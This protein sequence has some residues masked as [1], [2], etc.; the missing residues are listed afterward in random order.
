MAIQLIPPEV[1]DILAGQRP[2][3]FFAGAGISK[4]LP[5]GLPLGTDLA[6]GIISSACRDDRFLSA[7]LEILLKGVDDS[8]QGCRPEVLLEIARQGIGNR[9]V[10]IL[11]VLDAQDPNVYHYV[12]AHALIEGNVVITTNFDCMIEKAY[13]RVAERQHPLT[14]IITE[15]DCRNASATRLR[16][17]FL[18]KIHGSLF[19]RNGRRAYHS[20]QATLASMAIGLAPWKRDLLK[21]LVGGNDV[22]FLGYSGNDDF[23]VGPFLASYPCTGRFLWAKYK[24]QPLAFS[25]IELSNSEDKLDHVDLLVLRK[26]NS[27]VAEGDTRQLLSLLPFFERALAYVSNSSRPLSRMLQNGWFWR[28]GCS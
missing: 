9:V 24:R 5:T 20:I 15:H 13:Q 18:F 19:D 3:V 8:L 22:I 12:L 17:G 6:S 21:A 14:L 7:Y 1:E 11:S 2:K 23:D 26:R 25:N 10:Q 16:K 4:D 28:C 27:F